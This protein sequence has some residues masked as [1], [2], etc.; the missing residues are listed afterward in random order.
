ML[1]K[2]FDGPCDIIRVCC[3][4]GRQCVCFAV[5]CFIQYFQF[6]DTGGE[7]DDLILFDTVV[8]YLGPGRQVDPDSFQQQPLDLYEKYWGRP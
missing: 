6:N 3:D 1:L 8:L 2:P 7:N 5:P 4:F